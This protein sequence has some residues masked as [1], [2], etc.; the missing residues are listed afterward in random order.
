MIRTQTGEISEVW[1]T[2]MLD[3]KSRM[4]MGFLLTAGAPTTEDV[5]EV[6]AVA[7]EGATHLTEHGSVFVGGKPHTLHSDRGGDYVSWA[8]TVGLIEEAGIAR[9]FT[10]PYSPNSDGRV[11]A[12]H[13]TLERSICP[14]IP[15]YVSKDY[16]HRNPEALKPSVN[17]DDLLTL[18]ELSIVIFAQG[19]GLQLQTG[20]TPRWG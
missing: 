12:F 2:E 5:R 20:S 19:S 6:L 15:G 17:I 18:E 14:S 10:M 9:S 8:A 3:E 1:S 4:V 7:V 13:G 11:E 16:D